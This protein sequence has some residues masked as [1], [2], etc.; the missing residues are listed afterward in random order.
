MALS[1][2]DFNRFLQEASSYT[3]FGMKKYDELKALG[4]TDK[5]IQEIA[6]RAPIVGDAVAGMFPELTSWGV[7]NKGG[8]LSGTSARLKE[9]QIDY[10]VIP[11]EFDWVQYVKSNPDLKAAGIDTSEE[12]RRHYA[13]S[14]YQENRPNAPAPLP[15]R[16]ERYQTI[17]N[18]LETQYNNLVAIG[19]QQGKDLSY[20]GRKSDLP[21]I[22]NQQAAQLADAG[23]TSIAN[24]RQG[25]EDIRTGERFGSIVI[26]KNPILIDSVTG[27]K[28]STTNLGGSIAIDRDTGAQKFG[29]IFSGVEGG[30]N[31]GIQFAPDGSPILFPVHEK[32]KSPIAQLGLGGLE[33]VIGPVLTIAGAYYGMPGLG[34]VGGAAAGAAAG[35]TVGQLLASGDVDWGQV[36]TSAALAGGASYLSGAGGAGTADL[37]GTTTGGMLGSDAGFA[38]SQGAGT[39]GGLFADAS[40]VADYA[41]QMAE[42]E[43]VNAAGITQNLVAAGVDPGSAQLAANLATSGTSASSIANTLTTMAPAGT[44]GLFTA[45]AADLAAA[46][47]T[48]GGTGVGLTQQQLSAIQRGE[49]PGA[50]FAEQVEN[51][52]FILPAAG[53]GA[54]ATGVP[55][56]EANVATVTSGALKD[57]FGDGGIGGFLTGL[58]GAGI[59]YAALKAISDEARTL[60]RETEQRATAAGAAAN[61]PFTPYTVTT[62]AGTTAFGGTREAPTATV[63]AS[64][65]F[66]ALR[67]QALSQAGTTLGA[68]NPAQAAESLFQR[69]E[70]LAAPARQRE[71]EQLLSTL[72]SRGLLGV[73]RNLPTVGGTTAGVN[74]YLESLLSS[75]RTA[76][77]RSALEATQFGTA[78]AQRQAAL[79]N[80]LIGTGQNIDTAALATLTQG[81]NLGQFATAADQTSAANQLRATLAGQALRQQY[82]DLGLRAQAQGYLGAADFG[83]GLLGLPTQAGNTPSTNIVGNLL[84]KGFDYIFS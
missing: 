81:A 50:T 18:E 24:L 84:N 32:T 67:N 39:G 7:E 44:S 82:E 47:I 13:L 57:I 34:A 75:Q 65:E 37:S 64:P 36:A 76:Q 14:G 53:A 60:G 43:G 19:Q 21:A 71:T 41:K 59:D 49:I 1:T 27:K 40:F 38:V 62:G 10:S 54:T 20:Q 3:G 8:L 45:T 15:G 79:A 30:A 4:A 52:K 73:S 12:A 23:V 77:S 31:Y 5:Q 26:G 55:G 58:A 74:P 70:A 69:S 16:D 68:I 72:G 46:G 51:A 78:E 83:R 2:Q 28:V 66:Q 17:R 25:S 48:T 6:A 11:P 33:D 29:D 80:A 63:T 22:F 56:S 61:V 9:S 35:N 42:I